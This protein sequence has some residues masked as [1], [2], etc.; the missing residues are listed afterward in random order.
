MA[1]AV[2]QGDELLLEGLVL[3]VQLVLL[4]SHHRQL[5]HDYLHLALQ[6]LHL[7]TIPAL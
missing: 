4:L 1:E 5:L 2:A 3:F 6:L 7:T